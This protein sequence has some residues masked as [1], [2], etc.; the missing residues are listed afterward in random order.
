[1]DVKDYFPYDVDPNLISVYIGRVI[2]L[3][4]NFSSN[5]ILYVDIYDPDDTDLEK[6]AKQSNQAKASFA[7]RSCYN[8]WENPPEIKSKTQFDGAMSFTSSGDFHL[9]NYCFDMYTLTWIIQV[10]TILNIIFP[11][12]PNVP[13]PMI[14]LDTTPFPGQAVAV[15]VSVAAKE[16][17]NESIQSCLQNLTSSTNPSAPSIVSLDEVKRLVNPTFGLLRSSNPSNDPVV[18]VVKAIVD[19]IKTIANVA[20]KPYLEFLECINLLLDFY[21]TNLTTIENITFP[22]TQFAVINDDG[23]ATTPESL[24]PLAI[25]ESLQDK[26]N[27]FSTEIQDNLNTLIGDIINK[28]VELV[29]NPVA[30]LYSMVDSK[31]Q[32]IVVPIKNKIVGLIG[33]YVKEPL[34]Q[35]TGLIAMAIQPIISS[36]PT[37]VQLIVKLALKKLLQVLLGL[38][39]KVMLGAITSAIEAVLNGAVSKIQSMISELICTSINSLINPIIGGIQESFIKVIPDFNMDDIKNY[40]ISMNKDASKFPLI[41]LGTDA[42]KPYKSFNEINWS[43]PAEL[44]AMIVTLIEEV[45][46]RG[47]SSP[48]IPSGVTVTENKTEIYRV[49][50]EPQG[51]KQK[52]LAAV[53]VTTGSET[54]SSIP[55]DG[56]LKEGTLPDGSEF[57]TELFYQKFSSKEEFMPYFEQVHKPITEEAEIGKENTIFEK[58]VPEV[59]ITNGVAYLDVQ[60][61]DKK[62]RYV[63]YYNKDGKTIGVQTVVCSDG[64]TYSLAPNAV[65]YSTTILHIKKNENDPPVGEDLVPVVE[66]GELKQVSVP[67]TV[68][69]SDVREDADLGDPLYKDIDGSSKTFKELTKKY[70]QVLVPRTIDLNEFSKNIIDVLNNSG[71]PLDTTSTGNLSLIFKLT[72]FYRC[73]RK[74]GNYLYTIVEEQIVDDSV[75]PPVKE[76]VLRSDIPVIRDTN[77]SISRI[78]GEVGQKILKFTLSLGQGTLVIGSSLLIEIEGIVDTSTHKLTTCEFKTLKMPIQSGSLTINP[79]YNNVLLTG[80]VEEADSTSTEYYCWMT[81]KIETRPVSTTE[82]NNTRNTE[83]ITEQMSNMFVHTVQAMGQ[84][85]GFNA[86]ALFS[87]VTGKAVSEVGKVADVISNVDSVISSTLERVDDLKKVDAFIDKISEVGSK[88]KDIADTAGPALEATAKAASA[89]AIQSCSM[90]QSASGKD[91]SFNS[92]SNYDLLTTTESRSQLPWCKE[93]NREQFLEPNCKVLLMAVGAGKSN[94]YV[95]DILT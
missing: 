17:V 46:K 75:N 44:K 88:I 59:W 26:I 81:S 68:K 74:S 87:V 66:N 33:N 9:R 95:I 3:D 57:G 92:G 22:I 55:V 49:G 54:P 19:P 93:L 6:G 90:S 77:F 52:S 4:P 45:K 79:S 76:R 23:T 70:Y 27:A 78:D 71:E 36:L 83:S 13:P 43:D 61:G 72:E 25:K 80:T 64:N 38:P 41:Y 48:S 16:V 34:S 86:K 39:I 91:F 82:I 56:D 20:I 30:S 40:L 8:A 53:T 63:T 89:L 94:L 42:V 67:V 11:V 85:E 35:L 28:I 31:I 21:A 84:S 51:A 37:I 1:M 18:K 24:S 62:L 2:S 47:S 58:S 50:N 65:Y 14:S 69:D 10:S 73:M 29:Y 5:G 32:D 7:V 15:N 12:M 60:D